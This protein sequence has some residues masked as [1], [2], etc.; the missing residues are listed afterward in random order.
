ME[1]ENE[2]PPALEGEPT[3]RLVTS[4][5]KEVMVE[6]DFIQTC[7]TLRHM[8]EGTGGADASPA[9][10]IPLLTVP[11]V[12][13]KAVLGY[14]RLRDPQQTLELRIREEHQLE[15][16]PDFRHRVT[17]R[18]QTEILRQ[19][20]QKH[21]AEGVSLLVR[22]IVACEYLQF[23]AAMHDAMAFLAQQ[24]RLKSEGGVR[25]LFYPPV[26]GLLEQTIQK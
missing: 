5:N 20:A 15:A 18:G 14:S 6:P 3:I 11:E 24:L 16:S 17:T 26:S 7:V 23:M 13:L 21:D 19:M 25:S 2:L 8:W 22:F 1:S 12:V 9:G 4:D 10:A